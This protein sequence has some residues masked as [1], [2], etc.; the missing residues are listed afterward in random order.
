[1]KASD[2]KEQKSKESRD[3]K[4]LFN[5]LDRNIETDGSGARGAPRPSLE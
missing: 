1:M 4:F 5:L 3:R 2:L